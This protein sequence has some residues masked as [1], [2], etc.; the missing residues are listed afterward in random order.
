VIFEAVDL[1]S[2]LEGYEWV[3]FR[4]NYKTGLA[5]LIRQLQKTEEEDFP[6]PQKG[7]TV[8]AM[9]WVASVLSLIV[10]L[11]SLVTIW[12]I[13]IPFLLAPLP[14]R[15]F[16]RNFNFTQV[17]AALVMLP[18]ALFMTGMFVESDEVFDTVTSI[19]LISLPFIIALFFVLR[20]S[21]MQR[22][23]RPAATRPIFPNLYQPDNPNPEPVPF[24]VD[25][26][27]QDQ[28]VGEELAGVLEKYAHPRTESL[29]QAQAVFTVVSRFHTST[30]ADPE[31]QVVYPVILQMTEDLDEKLSKV[32]WIDFR[33]GVRNLDALA[34]LLPDPAK[35][36]KALGIRPMGK[37]LILPPIIQYL[38]YFIF[39]LAIFT[40]GSWLP[41]LLQFSTDILDYT[42]ADSALIMLFVNLVLFVVLSVFIAR[43]TISRRQP[44]ASH[45][46][47][48]I[49]MLGLGLLIVWQIVINEIIL[50]AFVGWE[51]DDD[52]R[53]LSGY[54]PPLVY[55]LGNGIMLIFVLLKRAD[56]RRW[57]PARVKK[58]K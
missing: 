12:T 9:V 41:Y 4:G 28:V 32:Q 51:Y 45:R 2:E 31:K 50:E 33:H 36:L 22:W 25:Y 49:A 3:D 11:S 1:P 40:V 13:F 27:P 23:G 35:L 48:F 37:Q 56:M 19:F 43:M 17:Q 34:Q 47:M 46:N 24:Y 54:F 20:S 52:Y 15:I 6:A 57:F 39:A 29:D 18:F 58:P 16:K 55:L 53:G 26:A 5:E 14:Y 38:I 10:S 42:D 7:F 21:G 44:W 8:P 30:Q